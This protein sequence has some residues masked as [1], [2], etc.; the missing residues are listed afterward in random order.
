MSR[1]LPFVMLT[2]GLIQAV[3][4]AAVFAADSA[5]PNI[6][7]ILADDFGYGD[8][9]ALN[10]EHGKIPT[11]HLDRLIEQGMTFTDTHSGSAVCTPTRYG[12]LTGRYCWRTRLQASVILKYAAPLIDAERLTVPGLLHKHGYRTAAIGK[13]HLGWNWPLD[14]GKLVLDQ[15][16]PDGPTGRG[17]QY[18]FGVDLPNLP[19]YGFI[20][21]N[22]LVQ[23]PTE[24]FKSDPKRFPH[25]FAEP[26]SEGPM[27]P[28][29]RFDQI[30]PKL[31]EKAVEYVTQRSADRQPFFL[32]FALT[33][34]H[35]PIAPSARFAGKS[36]ISPLADFLMETDW[37]VGQVMEALE[38][39]GQA[40][41]TLL[42]FTADNG[43]CPYTGLQ[44]LLDAGHWPSQRFRGYKADVW[45]GGHRV[46]L[47]ARW[48][49]VVKAGTTCN[50]LVCL[51]DL[52]ATCADLLGVKL[53][54]NAGEDSVSFLHLLRGVADGPRHEAVVHH[55]GLGRFAIRQGNWKLELCPGSGG[56]NNSAFS[57]P[58]DVVAMKNGLPDVQLYDLSRDD[59]E[60]ANV[61]DKHPEVVQ[62]LT[63]LLE[64]YVAEGRS[65]PGAPQ[66]NDVPVDIWKRPAKPEPKK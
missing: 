14:D 42:I 55:S 66:A 52:L 53:P 46:P 24:T 2:L 9:R 18:F 32:Y 57:V 62:Q 51:T 15:S 22:R 3:F 59:V 25:P 44:P 54:D 5:R 11:P 40:Q 4:A 41:N 12:I 48:P 13:W 33:S 60:Q 6:V 36:G 64:K 7:Y 30:L 21:N 16:I 29:W 20:E 31:T 10:P 17:F 45:E 39:S 43:H 23:Q 34:P 65:T 19:P 8:I 27:V 50:Q 38:K 1:I 37:A 47:V 49:G 58:S 28:G 26:L 61:Q 35:E 63:K 56:Y